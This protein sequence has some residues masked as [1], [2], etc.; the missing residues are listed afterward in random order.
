LIRAVALSLVLLSPSLAFAQED[1]AVDLRPQEQRFDNLL[2]EDLPI[3][4]VPEM[5]PGMDVPAPASE[6]VIISEEV[7]GGSVPRDDAYGA[8]QRG[9]FL[10][11]LALALPRAKR[12][13]AAAQTLIAELY[14]HGLGVPENLARASSWYALASENG[15]VLATFELAM[16]YEQGRGV[17]KSRERAAELFRK[18]ADEGNIAAKYNLALLHVEGRYAEPD[19]SKAAELLKEAAESG[20]PEAMYDYGLMLIEGAGVKPD[21]AA[22]AE[23]IRLA[24]EEGLASAQVEYATLLYIGRGVRR[25][26]AE[27]VEWY[28]RAAIAGN[29]VAQNRL[30]KLLAVGEGV[31]IDLQEAAMWRALARRQGLTDSQL[32]ELL[33]AIP[34]EDLVRAEDRARF[35]P[36]DP[37]DAVVGAT[38]VMIDGPEPLGPIEGLN[39]P[40]A[41]EAAVAP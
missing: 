15:D 38:P 34:P 16:L 41:P 24:A 29:P 35:W 40:K 2:V 21:L 27:A 31:G 3:G 18:A 22:G 32:D 37:P 7:L 12:G 25:E 4:S 28:R 33:A 30:A 5:M 9:H 36:A 14:A 11:A 17:P 1:E 39:L 20:M 13:D 23:Q 8:Y 19:L 10:T 6:A 26:R